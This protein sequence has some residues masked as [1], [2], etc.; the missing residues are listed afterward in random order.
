MHSGIEVKKNI[1]NLYRAP[2]TDLHCPKIWCGLVHSTLCSRVWNLPFPPV[3]TTGEK[4]AKFSV[5]QPRF[6]RLR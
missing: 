5:T 6:A 3:E 4:I 1:D 2:I